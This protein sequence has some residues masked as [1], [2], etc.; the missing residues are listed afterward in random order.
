MGDQSFLWNGRTLVWFS[1]GAASAVAAK[2]AVERN[3]G[4]S[5]EVCYCDTLAYEH[6]DN[7]R[8]MADVSRWI[9]RDVKILRS[10]KY[11]DIFE[12]FRGERYLD[13][14]SGAPCTRALKRRVRQAYQ[15]PWDSHVFGFTVDE[16]DRIDDFEANNPDL[17]CLWILR[18][19]GINKADCY[20]IVRD[21]GIEL[22]TMYRLGYRNNNC[23][24]CVK[25][26]AGY[27]NK[28]RRDFPEAFD[29]MAR[30]EREIG[31][32][33]CRLGGR[34][35]YLDEL[36]PDAGRYQEEPDFECGPQCVNLN[37]P[38]PSSPPP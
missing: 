21:A 35:V 4:E 32:A 2:M 20:R 1:C 27:W 7:R 34:P 25:G 10:P 9:G 19:E 12:V 6:P 5:I 14:P 16:Q 15:E 13:G 24:G 18:D 37:H 17:R 33:L 30:L 3:Q 31:H 38:S 28:I 23:I 11:R 36:P 26:R 29:R 8:F 22:P